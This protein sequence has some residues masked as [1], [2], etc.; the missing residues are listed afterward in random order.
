MTKSELISL[1]SNKFPQL[2]HLDASLSIQTILDNMAHAL[3]NNH[4]IEIRGFG[5]F[6]VNIRPPRLGRNPKTGEK[7]QVA[8]KRVPHFKPGLVLKKRVL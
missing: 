3:A 5:S 4:R 1:L 6:N 2:T 7:V 8:A